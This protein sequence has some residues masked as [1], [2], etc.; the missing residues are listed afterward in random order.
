VVNLEA[1]IAVTQNFASEHEVSD[2]THSLTVVA[3]HL[4]PQLVNVLRFMRDKADQTSGWSEDIPCADLYDKFCT[5]LRKER[6]TLLDNA[7]KVLSRTR[8]RET[9]GQQSVWDQVTKSSDKVQE[10]F[11][12]GFDVD[13]DV[14]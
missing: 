9:A 14:E 6:P 8:K 4:N 3:E 7:L 13:D 2:D 1:S 5:V 10:G 11:S 12:F